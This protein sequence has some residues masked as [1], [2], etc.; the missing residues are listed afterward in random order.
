VTGFAFNGHEVVAIPESAR[1]GLAS[2]EELF[3]EL[4][5]RFK[6]TQY[7]PHAMN[8]TVTVSQMIDRALV[9]SEMLGGLS[10]VEREYCT[11][12]ATAFDSRE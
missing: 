2:T 6:M 10:G 5:C 4:I 7:E 9:L 12:D 11:V 8:M 3:R 1:L